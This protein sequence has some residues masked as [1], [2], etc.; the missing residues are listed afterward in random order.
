MGKID[1]SKWKAFTVGSL[2]YKLNLKIIKENFNKTMDVSTSRTSEFSLP[3]VNAKHFDNGIMYYG[4]ECDFESAEM[5][6]D[7]VKNGA[8]ATADNPVAAAYSLSE[9]LLRRY[10]S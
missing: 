2:F 9:I 1:T 10:K 8:I 4:R 3:L 5:T 7:V 6:L